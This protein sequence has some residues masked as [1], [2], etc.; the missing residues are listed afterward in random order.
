MITQSKQYATKLFAT[1]FG[2]VLYAYQ[3]LVNAC[4][5]ECHS[6]HVVLKTLDGSLVRTNQ[7]IPVVVNREPTFKDACALA[8]MLVA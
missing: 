8:E 6:W 3:G 5:P 2:Q 1:E 7:A 4:G